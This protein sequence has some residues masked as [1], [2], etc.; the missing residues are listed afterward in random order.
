ML[1]EI[2]ECG[3]G[4]FSVDLMVG[5]GLAVGVFEGCEAMRVRLMGCNG[6]CWE[7]L[8]GF[9]VFEGDEGVC[10]EDFADVA[11]ELLGRC[12]GGHAWAVF[13]E[14]SERTTGVASSALGDE[15]CRLR[16]GCLICASRA[17]M[18][19]DCGTASAVG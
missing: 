17:R 4:E 12:D 16:S 9:F 13:T 2:T 6:V 1:E 5:E 18:C 8:Q 19:F 14:M 15:G 7:N 3:L 11:V 10:G